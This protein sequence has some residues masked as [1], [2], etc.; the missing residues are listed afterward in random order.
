MRKTR[1]EVKRDETKMRNIK[2]ANTAA[3]GDRGSISSFAHPLE[4][5]P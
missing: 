2:I 3:A 1:C 4:F 5:L